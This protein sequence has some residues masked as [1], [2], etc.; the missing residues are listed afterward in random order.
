MGTRFRGWPEQAYAVLLQLGRPLA[1]HTVVAAE[2]TQV[3]ASSEGAGNR[4]RYG[5]PP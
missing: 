2:G 5:V 1:E 4:A 3:A